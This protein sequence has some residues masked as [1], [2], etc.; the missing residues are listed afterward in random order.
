MAASGDLHIIASTSRSFD[1]CNGQNSLRG[2]GYPGRGCYFPLMAHRYIC[3]YIYICMRVYVHIYI[4]YIYMCMYI[5]ICMYIC[6]YIYICMLT[7]LPS[8]T[9]PPPQ[10]LPFHFKCP[11]SCYFK[12][13]GRAHIRKKCAVVAYSVRVTS[14]VE[15]QQRRVFLNLLL[16]MSRV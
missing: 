16:A 14:H 7:P 11:K 15:Y 2:H 1:M 3:I 12:D 6:I 5:Y 10:C 13:M 8:A 4:L 9:P